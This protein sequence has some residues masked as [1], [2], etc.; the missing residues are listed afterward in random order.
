MAEVVFTFWDL[1][2]MYLEFLV[3]FIVYAVICSYFED[4]KIFKRFK[5]EVK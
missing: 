1:E 4:K 5:K 3:G 2:I